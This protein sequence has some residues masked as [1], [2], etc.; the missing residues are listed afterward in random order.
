M[1]DAQSSKLSAA[2]NQMIERLHETAQRGGSLRE[3][4]HIIRDAMVELGE[5]SREEAEQVAGY[6]ERDIQ[7]AARF[8]VE[9]GEDLRE[10]WRFDVAL[11]EERLWEWFSQVADQTRLQLQ[12]L[13]ER[14]RYE[15]RY[16]SGEISGPGTLICVQCGHEILMKETGPIPPCPQCQGTT[17]RR[18]PQAAN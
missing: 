11:M 10:W 3:R 15:S 17:F 6:V 13:A 8:L 7:E 4:L 12:A 2:Y 18:F 14:A 1:T 5:L 9:T 16:T